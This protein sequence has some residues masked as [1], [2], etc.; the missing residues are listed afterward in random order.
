M[1]DVQRAAPEP[2]SRREYTLVV[3]VADLGSVEQLMRTAIDLATAHDG[4]ILV[5][6]VIHKTAG[7]PFRLFSDDR[8][9]AEF[10]EGRREV[11]DRAV[12]AAADAPVPVE[13]R[14]LV[15]TDVAETILTAVGDADA[16]GLLLGWQTRPRPSDIVLGTTVDP[17]IRRAPC[18]VFVERVGT[19]AD[20]VDA[21]LLPTVGGPHVE[22]AT[23]LVAAVATANDAT[24][25][26]VSYVSPSADETE[27]A[28]A[29]EHAES[30]SSQLPD[31][32][33][34]GGVR[35]SDDIAGSVVTAAADHDL[36]VLGATRERRFR[37]RVVGSVAETVSRRADPPVVIAKRRSEGTLF[38]SV[39]DRW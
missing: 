19:T 25:T 24:A 37:R 10:S 29:R 6:S 1:A 30:A 34:E 28:A 14:L 21:I 31:V 39:F 7:S 13:D 22:P 11:L 8:I 20:G 2:S 16:D 38:S 26:V 27:R 5:V 23:D 12:E 32:P 4:S 9:K 18:D 17:V 15:G 36:V 33:V 3:A 35:E